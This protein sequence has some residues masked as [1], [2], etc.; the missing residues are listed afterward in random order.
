[1]YAPEII[2]RWTTPRAD[3]VDLYWHVSTWDPYEVVLMRT[4]LPASVP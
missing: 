2:E 3:A 4:R 1:M